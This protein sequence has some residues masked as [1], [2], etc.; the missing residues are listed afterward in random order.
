MTAI[1]K[2]ISE[3]NDNIFGYSF[4]AEYLSENVLVEGYSEV[5]DKQPK[6]NLCNSQIVTIDSR[7]VNFKFEIGKS[8]SIECVLN[9]YCNNPEMG[10]VLTITKFNYEFKN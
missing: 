2:I 6:L 8:Y 1:I 9:L 3:I 10:I 5:V 4:K 7:P